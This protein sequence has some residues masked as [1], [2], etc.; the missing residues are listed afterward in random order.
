M[1]LKIW[2]VETTSRLKETSLIILLWVNK[3]LKLSQWSIFQ[4]IKMIWISKSRFLT[5][6]SVFNCFQFWSA[7]QFNVKCFNYATTYLTWI[8]NIDTWFRFEN[9]ETTSITMLSIFHSEKY[10]T[11]IHMNQIWNQIW[12]QKLRIRFM[13]L[14]YIFSYERV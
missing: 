6:N 1:I 3:N 7:Q 8:L 4:T 12:I 13:G 14:P 2:K 11:K 10:D 9:E 5:K